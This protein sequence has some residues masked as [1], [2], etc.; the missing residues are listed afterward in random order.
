MSWAN[1]L[2]GPGRDAA[3]ALI[4]LFEQYG[5]DTLAPKIVDYLKQGYQSDTI[6]LLLQESKE[7]KTRFAANELRRKKGLSVLSPAEYIQNER[8]YRQ[9]LQAAGVP[10]GFYDSPK[11]LQDFLVKDISP[12][13]IAERA[14]TARKV[15]DSVDSTQRQ[16]L[17][18]AGLGVGDLIAHYLDADR[19]LPVL[20]KKVDVALLNAE[21]K[22]AGYGYS[23]KRAE[24]LYS[25]GIT[26]EQAREGSSAI[27]QA[28]P[29]FER[30]GDI[31]G[32]KLTLNDME[33]EVFGGDAD[34]TNRRSR[35]ASQ[36]RAQFEG[37]AASG[38]STL[39]RE[40]QFN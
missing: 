23:D 5:L 1:E 33:N 9:A 32:S 13:E 4:D 12:S 6:Y 2:R 31:Y 14:M 19:A 18:R 40:R 35:L 34:A 30:L 22:R 27:G 3:A 10:A 20:Q 25:Q 24:D 39:G 11:D 21:R 28:L 26:T 17:A 37:S 8:A 36:E 15:V 38:R 7:W 29:T 16:A